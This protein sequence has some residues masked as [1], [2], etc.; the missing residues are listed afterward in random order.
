[1]KRLLSLVCMFCV[2]LL[3]SVSFV[4][5]DAAASSK[6]QKPDKSPEK[7]IKPSFTPEAAFESRQN[8]YPIVLVHGFG[9]WGRDEALG[10]LY[11]GGFTDI[12]EDLKDHGY[13]TYTAAVGPVSSN[14]DRACE[15]YAQIK[16]GRVDY[17]EAHSREHGHER[18][19]KTHSGFFPEWGEVDPRSG[20]VNKV[21]LIGHSQGGQTVRLL[22]HL[23]ENGDAREAEATSADELSPLFHPEKKLWVHS[24]V[25][26]SS[27]HNGTTLTS[28]VGG[29]APHAQQIIALIAAATGTQDHP[30]Y[31]FKL[32]HWGLKKEKGE[33]FDSYATRV[34][35]SRIWKESKDTSQ[36]DLSPDGAM[37]LNQWVQAQPDVYYFSVATEQTFRELFTGYEVA[38]PLMNP[39]FY[40]S[41]AYMGSYTRD[42]A[43]HVEIDR[44]WWKNDGIVNTSSMPGPTSGSTDEIV[45]YD[46]TPE[47]GKWNYLGLLE[48]FDHADVIGIG[49]RDMR[50]WYRGL[51][52]MLGSLPD[53]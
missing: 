16:G 13:P 12:E 50:R 35:N 52:E 5:A 10:Y 46:G 42:D 24:V 25:T 38:E 30:L 9:G 28:L 4:P 2:C 3:I 37:E 31:D 34:Y 6:N 18:F 49:V 53:H 33:S 22:T 1:M 17:G 14:W 41:A 15:L 51:A 21:H 48:S 45:D 44:S 8:E 36:W 11:W 23:L 20:K 47:P 40:I 39:L 32:D 29:I 7:R 19:G 43:D 26:I 27:P